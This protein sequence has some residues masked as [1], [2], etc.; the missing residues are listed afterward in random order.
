M[1]DKLRRSRRLDAVQSGCSALS[2]VKQGDLMVVANVGDSW[3]VLGTAFDDDAITSS[4]SSSTSS[5][6][7]H[8]YYLADEPGMHFVLQPSQKSSV[9]G[10]SRTFDDYYIEDCG[11]ILAPEVT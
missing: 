1:Y 6:T 3:V 4:S 10:M 7:C 5:P 11:V 8:G 2:I 9:L